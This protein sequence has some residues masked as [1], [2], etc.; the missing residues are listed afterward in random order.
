[1]G[2]TKSQRD[3]LLDQ[4]DFVTE[5]QRVRNDLRI[6]HVTPGSSVFDRKT[7]IYMKPEE[8]FRRFTS[9]FWTNRSCGKPDMYT[10]LTNTRS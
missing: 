10:N 3:E 5:A 2:E 7:T 9:G 8:F 1:M 4:L 6:F